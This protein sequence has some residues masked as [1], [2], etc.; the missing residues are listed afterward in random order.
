MWSEPRFS[1][2]GLAI[3]LAAVG[4][5]GCGK[6]WGGRCAAGDD[7]L[8]SRDEW[9]LIQSLANVSKDPPPADDSNELLARVLNGDAG[10]VAGTDQIRAV[11]D[12]VQAA[13]SSD[14]LPAIVRLGWRLYHDPR[15]SG[16]GNTPK[17]SVGRETLPPRGTGQIGVSCASCHD[18]ARY[19]ADF[20][21]LPP[22]VSNGAGYY[23]VN[24][25][26][27]LNVARFFPVYYWNGRADSLWSQAAQ[28]ME[29]AV[30][31]HGRRE[32]T[33]WLIAQCYSNTLDFVQAFADEPDMRPSIDHVTIDEIT[34]AAPSFVVPSPAMATTVEF[35]NSFSLARTCNSRIANDLA[36]RVHRKVAKAIAA[37]EWFL[38]SDGSRF[39]RFVAA[40]PS[41]ALLTAS[42]RRGLKLFVGHA[43]CVNCHNTSLFSD[44]KFHNIGVGQTGDH[45]PTVAVCTK[46]RDCDCSPTAPPGDDGGVPDAGATGAPDSLAVGGKC[47]PAGA[48][49]GM[50]RL[51]ADNTVDKMS[52]TIFRRC[53]DPGDPQQR[54]GC[55]V[56]NGPNDYPN[57]GVDRPPA[58]WL[59]AWRT[60]SLRDVAMTAPYMHDGSLESLSDVVW[61]YDQAA[62][63]EGMGTS[64]LA[65]LNLTQQDRADLVAFLGTL[66]GQPGPSLLVS[67]PDAAPSCPAVA[68]D[69]GPS[70]ANDAGSDAGTDGP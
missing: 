35:Q 54:Y 36:E 33:L 66:T 65:P 34:A 63:G 37:Y 68:V 24:G 12:G 26:Q 13:S 9:T 3:V 10:G 59:G 5:L 20:T 45:V 67:P 31:M 39:D 2:T 43:G 8:Y 47:L 6:G 28:V 21:S 19:G 42:E 48:Y 11:W 25:Q 62:A 7:C 1:I 50:Q 22:N 44:R 32:K 4:A 38:T 15:F 14:E 58:R 30:S 51:H 46:G 53:S 57:P 69:A 29:S 18:P 41:S 55:Q 70:C 61:H 56:E 17:D 52:P 49:A 16:D 64:E 23:D 27:T 60:P 40:G